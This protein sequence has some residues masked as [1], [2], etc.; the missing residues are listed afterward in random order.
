MET[1]TVPN[2]IS[3][4][5]LEEHSMSVMAGRR[6]NS[7]PLPGPMADAFAAGAIKVGEHRVRKVVASDWVAF[8]QI[9]SPVL[10]MILDLQQGAGN[11]EYK[12]SEVEF[13]DQQQWELAWQFIKTPKEVRKAIVD[14][15]IS[16]LAEAE[17]GDVIEQPIVMLLIAAVMEQ[18]KRSWQTA[19][20]YGAEA[21]KNGDITFFRDT[22]AMR[23]MASGGGSSTSA[24]S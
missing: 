19:V 14:G 7:E 9:K 11:P 10:E 16:A 22:E 6:A 24:G 15:T 18:L 21:K 4:E 12:P 1:A 20:K 13:S 2:G 17:I 3:K 5:R 23:K 8:K